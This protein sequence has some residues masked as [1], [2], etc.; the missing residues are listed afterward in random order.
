MAWLDRASRLAPGDLFV[1]LSLASALA[2]LDDARALRL[3]E[4]IVDAGSAREAHLGL[5][6][7][8]MRRG[9]CGGAASALHGMLRR[10]APLPDRGFVKTAN[11]IAVAA[12]FQGWVGADATGRVTVALAEAPERPPTCTSAA[13]RLVFRPAP[14]GEGVWIAK[15]PPEAS[16]HPLV[17]SVAGGVTLLGNP[18]DL[19]ELRRVEG[20]VEAADGGLRGW[21][22]YP[23]TPDTKPPVRLLR[24]D[25]KLDG[26]SALEPG[27]LDTS[28]DPDTV[29]DGPRWLLS[30][31]REAIPGE[32]AVRVVGTDGRDLLGSPVDPTLEGR[33]AAAAAGV[34]GG[35]TGTMRRQ[36]RTTAPWADTARPLPALAPVPPRR[37]A[38]VSRAAGVGI[39]IPAYRGAAEFRACLTSVLDCLPRDAEVVVVNDG[40]PDSALVE[41]VEAAARG[42]L[43]RVVHHSENRG[44]PAAVNS[45]LRQLR[46]RDVILL[47]SDTVVPEGWVDRLRGLAYACHDT[48]SVT[49]FTN[50]GSIAS[51]PDPAGS[52]MPADTA[53]VDRV[54]LAANGGEGVEIPTGVGFCMYLR[55]DCLAEVGLL[56]EDVF[57]QG[58]GEE[59]DWCMRA[60]RLGWRHVLAT[61]LF[62][63][64]VGGR[65]FGGAK[66]HL[67]RRNG[68]I[69]ESLHPGYGELVRGSASHPSLVAAR[70]RADTMR[71]RAASRPTGAIVMVTHG[72]GGGVD[73]HVA[74]RAAALRTAGLRPVVLRPTRPGDEAGCT[75]SEGPEGDYPNLVFA[76]PEEIRDLVA[77]LAGDRVRRV[78]IHHLLG[79]APDLEQ[80]AGLLGVPTHVVVHDNAWICP[81]VSLLGR[82]GRYCGEPDADECAACVD[83]LGEVMPERNVE[84]LRT[85]S[86]RLLGGAELVTVPTRD[87]ADRLVR[88]LGPLPR[89]R[90]TPWE[91]VRPPRSKAP[92]A[93]S[94]HGSPVVAVVG[95]IG[96]EK[97]YEV[98]LECARDATRRELPLSFLVVGHTM[99]DER[100][101]RTGRV[102]VTG[103]FKEGEAGPLLAL[104]R[105]AAGFVSSVVPETWCYALS[106]LLDAGLPTASFDLGAQAERLRTV[107]GSLLLTSNS[108]PAA[109]ND[110]LV[111]WL[112]KGGA[113]SRGGDRD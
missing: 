41:E 72:R 40:S 57:A 76:F 74:A 109:I 69:L 78:E 86:A 75:L 13:G 50:D 25:A 87:V 65:S 39:V 44:F 21:V 7:L 95:A 54:L 70:R 17:V 67:M 53:A 36:G 33:L 58:Y 5:A 59:N 6:V 94:L 99:D 15:V 104:H 48:G 43:V 28:G 92:P 62:V 88:H 100:L 19:A 108:E 29:V 106:E 60:R 27:G 45:G 80:L 85:A 56:R 1:R 16:A 66:S 64:H 91:A 4:S 8:R 10:F 51:Y 23:S 96:L 98:L 47:N 71:W 52:G 84:Q 3:F 73:R 11:R 61:G 111:A 35:A 93:R 34:I 9:D 18:P 77:L 110:A 42:G 49:P 32:G 107:P 82:T 101:L 103:E 112:S 90:V 55:H 22:R 105:P 2:G 46:G 89:L 37:P 12:G 31:P 14:S 113:L 81:R 20:F 102:F 97:G 30:V 26:A 24:V 79:H 38:K 63:A 68:A 83:D